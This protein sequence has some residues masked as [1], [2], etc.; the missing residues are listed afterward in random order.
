[1][2]RKKRTASKWASHRPEKALIML[3]K[4]LKIPAGTVKRKWGMNNATPLYEI[5][6]PRLDKRPAT[7]NGKYRGTRVLVR[8]PLLDAHGG[9]ARLSRNTIRQAYKR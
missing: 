6:R 8:V 4:G 5:L 3:H 9:K 2:T 7:P 1:M